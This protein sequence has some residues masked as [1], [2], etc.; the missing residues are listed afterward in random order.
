M[1]EPGLEGVETKSQ[2]NNSKSSCTSITLP[3]CS[4]EPIPREETPTVTPALISSL[5]MFPEGVG[6]ISILPITLSPSH[7]Y[8]DIRCDTFFRF[9][10]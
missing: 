10:T 3:F 2:H 4:N 6:N 8:S 9:I 5:R 1:Y 7:Q